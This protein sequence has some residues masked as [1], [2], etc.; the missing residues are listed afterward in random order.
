MKKKSIVILLA[1]FIVLVLAVIVIE[2]PLSKRGKKK[3]AEESILF[4]GFA[5]D[6]VSS[7]EIRTKDREIKLNKEGESWL[8]A[9]SDNYP[10]DTEAVRAVLD[11]VKELKLTLI[12]SKA[13]EKHSQFEV[14]ESGVEVKMLGAEED[15]L[16][17]FF[18][19]KTGPGYMSTYVRKADQDMV[20]LIDEPLKYTFDKGERGWRDRTVFDFDASQVQRLTL[21]S[22]EKGEIAIVA[23]EDGGWQIIKP[24]VA[25]AE[26]EAVDDIVR[27]ISKLSADD[28]AEKRKEPEEEEAGETAEA[29]VA[30]PLKEY[31]LDEPQSKVMVDLKDGTAR[32][33]LIGD[34]SGYQHY[35]KREGKDT[36]FMLS[37]SKI[38]RLFKDLEDL[39]AE[40][41]EEK[42]E[43]EQ[44]AEEAKPDEESKPEE[45]S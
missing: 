31:K 35:V 17:H 22:E 19:G 28:F 34:K 21:V 20:L 29:E 14:D 12:A 8:V 23:Q 27:D 32:V 3:A 9:T 39:K 10:A 40:M 44:E 26:K 38:D 15:V 18:V 24:E 7:V 5:A 2:G 33:L 45:A 4:P 42:P 37:K 30:S 41:E 1:I 36:I 13:A 11:N 16:A 25:S 6:Q 43:G